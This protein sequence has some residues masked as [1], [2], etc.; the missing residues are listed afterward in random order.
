VSEGVQAKMITKAYSTWRGYDWAGPLFTY[1]G[2]DLGTSNDRRETHFGLLRNDWSQKPAYDAYR[3]A[4]AAATG[5]TPANPTPA[6]PA[7]PAQGGRIGLQALKGRIDL[8][9]KPTV[10][11]KKLKLEVACDGD[12][13]YSCTKARLMLQG[14]PKGKNA[15]GKD[16]VFARDTEVRV[17]AGKTDKLSLKLTKR[18]RKLFGGPNGVKRIRT[19]VF[20]KGDPAGI[21]TTKRTGKVE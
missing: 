10:K 11:G 6:D 16:A 8:D 19:E 4:V 2:R 17:A 13:N 14:A 7:T 20:I 1:Q 12:A 9:G 5:A 15:R 3:Q 21:T 18:A